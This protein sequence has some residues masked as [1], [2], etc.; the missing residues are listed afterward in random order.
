MNIKQL[1][2]EELK[3]LA[4]LIHSSYEKSKQAEIAI[5]K[6]FNEVKGY[7]EDV[8][9]NVWDRINTDYKKI[10]LPH[11]YIRQEKANL[12]REFVDR[13]VRSVHY[14]KQPVKVIQSFEGGME[15]VLAYCC[16][17]DFPLECYKIPKTYSN[18]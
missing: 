3:Q 4:H 10:K 7:S 11:E 6:I 9:G 16:D 2:H 8:F 13:R 12:E 18:Y 5:N 17:K 1:K 15:K 14:R